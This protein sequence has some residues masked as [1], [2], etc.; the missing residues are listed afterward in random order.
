M[1]KIRDEQ[2]EK[3]KRKLD[4]Y[5]WIFVIPAT[6]GIFDEHNF[7]LISM[8]VDRFAFVAFL[9]FIFKAISYYRAKKKN[10]PNR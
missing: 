6:F 10:F 1:K 3:Q 4:I 5:F 9:A 7:T 2:F 8:I